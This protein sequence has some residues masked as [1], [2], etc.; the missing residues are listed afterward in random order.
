MDSSRCSRRA[1]AISRLCG[2]CD[3]D[4][5]RRHWRRPTLTQ[6]RALSGLVSFFGTLAM[7]LSCLGIYGILAYAVS[8]RTPEIGVRMALGARPRHVMRTVG[9]QSLLIVAVGIVGGTLGAGIAA[10]WFDTIL[11]RVSPADPWI[12]AGSA[13][14]L[15]TVA[16]MAMAKPVS[17]A[18]RINPL[19]ALHEE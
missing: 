17:R 18:C 8:R 4:A 6:I 10:R 1:A 2:N 12:L 16:V 3:S 5:G 15:L 13:A 14:L 7:L 11:F 9:A 19:E